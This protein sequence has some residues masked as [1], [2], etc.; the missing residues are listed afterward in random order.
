MKNL[1]NDMLTHISGEV[2]TLATCWKITRRDSEVMAFTSH[3]E[4]IYFES[5]NYL[6][7]SGFNPTAILSS[8]SL[9]V[10]NMDVE[11]ILSSES[12]TEEDILAGKYDYAE[13]N[14]FMVNYSNIAHGAIKLKTGWIGEVKIENGSYTA[15]IRGLTQALSNKI[16][17]LYA[18]TCRAKLG[19]TRCK[20]NM[21]SYTLSGSVTSAT[22]NSEFTDNSRSEASGYFNAG[23]VTF[24]S[25]AN[26]GLSGE[27]K[28]FSG[29]KI[30]LALPM[31]Y[32]IVA[33]NTFTIKAG[34][35]KTFSTCINKFNNAVN[36]RGEPHV[37]GMDK[38]LETAGTRS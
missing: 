33:G 27:V 17:E 25:G 4:D 12:I 1:S 38:I 6:A 5:T 3:S 19:D 10:D 8:N 9:A 26:S 2:T 34:C 13:V 16:G 20:V 29:K 11:G 32:A 35:D 7:A 23:V 21:A 31:P 28:E 30:K 24:T 22:G 37:P 14:I 18:P 36:F 15:E